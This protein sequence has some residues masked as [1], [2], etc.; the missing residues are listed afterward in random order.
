MYRLY[1]DGICR[2]SREAFQSG[3]QQ[4]DLK[5]TVLKTIFVTECGRKNVSN[6]IGQYLNKAG[7]V[8]SLSLWNGAHRLRLALD[9]V[10]K[11]DGNTVQAGEALF[12]F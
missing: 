1:R 7:P 12:V 11:T 4:T 2:S 6:S 8:R 9:H 3:I 10:V 5:W